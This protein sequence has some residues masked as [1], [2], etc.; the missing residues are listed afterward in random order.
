MKPINYAHINIFHKKGYWF[1][2]WME[3][4]RPL[5]AKIEL[6]YQQL[7]MPQLSGV[8]GV[9]SQPWGTARVAGA[10]EVV[11]LWHFVFNW[12]IFF[13]PVAMLYISVFATEY[14]EHKEHSIIDI[15]SG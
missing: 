12:L 13:I 3:L 10:H 11:W 5:L 14:F 2:I 1:K 7:A 9:A 8:E 4:L 15:K 6:I